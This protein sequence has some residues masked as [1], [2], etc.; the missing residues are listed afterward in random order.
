MSKFFFGG[1]MTFT[2]NGTET[3]YTSYFI[4]SNR[5]PQQ[6]SLLGMLRFLILK[7]AGEDV[8]KDNKIMNKTH[9]KDLIGGSSFKVDCKSHDKSYFGYIDS[10]SPCFLM[11]GDKPLPVHAK[12]KEH[13][14]AFVNGVVDTEYTCKTDIKD[15][16]EDIFISDI[17]MGLKK[18]YEG[19][20]RTKHEEEKALFKQ[21]NLRFNNKEGHAYKFAFY[22]TVD[23]CVAMTSYSTQ[24]V[25][26]GADGSMFAITI[27]EVEKIPDLEVERG[28]IEGQTLVLTSPAYID[29]EKMSDVAYAITDVKPFKFMNTTVDNTKEYNRLNSDIEYS[30]RFNLYQRGSVFFF[31]DESAKV[32][33]IDILKSYKDFRQI[34]YNYYN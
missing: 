10:I 3:N 27:K 11:D 24:M 32:R 28:K 1:D 20:K 6:T 8:F 29:I 30:E 4:R 7:N 19:K 5:F 21:E 12:A 2:I 25:S 14:F 33:F 31:E 9:A 15:N 26:L 22:A 18:D 17:R 13:R 34:G 16:E 23:E